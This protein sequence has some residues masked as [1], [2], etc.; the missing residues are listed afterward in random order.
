MLKLISWNVNGL[1]S[2]LSKGFMDYFSSASP[3]ICCLQECK[4]T[5]GALTLDL[6]GYQQ[7]F[8]YAE[9]NGYSGTAIF[10]KE[11]PLS[12]TYGLGIDEH[13]HEGRVIV[14]EYPAFQ[15]VNIY[16][17]NAQ[18]GLTRLDYRMAWEEDMCAFLCRLDEKKPVVFCGDLNVAHTAIDIKN[19][20][21]NEKNAGFTPQEREK[22]TRLL[23]AGFADTFR[24]LHPEARDAYTWWSY[25]GGAR[26]RNV[27]WRI[28]YFC[29]SRRMLP[30]VLSAG[31]R[32][33]ITGSDHCPIEL[34]L[35]I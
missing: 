10:T 26:E 17:P 27:G 30:N 1:R 34:A 13:D 3:D 6:P 12:V 9:K 23:E 29:V 19:A 22:F 32:P 5:P 15:L 25:M 24:Q 4:L 21:A 18:R 8:S 33:E 11:E 14:A 31:I 20:K 2:C 28:D 35:A 16:V 7:Y